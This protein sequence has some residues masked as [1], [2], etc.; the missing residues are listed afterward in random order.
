MKR[1][2]VLIIFVFLFN[3]IWVNAISFTNKLASHYNIIIKTNKQTNLNNNTIIEGLDVILENNLTYEGEDAVIIGKKIDNYLKNELSGSGELIAK[4]AINYKINPY[5]IASMIIENTNCDT[6]CT[7]LVKRC[8]NVYNAIYNKDNINETSCFG[9]NYQ[10]FNT[11]EDSIKSFIKYVKVN[12][13]DQELTTP[14]T[15]Y[16]AYKKDASWA[17][18]VNEYMNKIKSSK[19]E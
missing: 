9:G 14:N 7:T 4:Y 6:N 1:K 19:I 16:K 2:I 15:I 11:K 18:W 8:N 17:F 13:Y 3:I 12:F 5:L 10:K